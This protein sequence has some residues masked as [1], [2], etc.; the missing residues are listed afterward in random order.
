[1]IMSINV[2]LNCSFIYTRISSDKF[3]A[4]KASPI[5]KPSVTRFMSTVSAVLSSFRIPAYFTVTDSRD[6]TNPVETNVS[7]ANTATTSKQS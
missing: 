6:R 2:L 4:I 3:V 7:W 1:M 5:I